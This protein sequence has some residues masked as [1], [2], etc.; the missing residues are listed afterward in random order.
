MGTLWP[1]SQESLVNSLS[2]LSESLG[3]LKA[4]QPIDIWEVTEHLQTAAESVRNLR[5]LVT[6][7]LSAASWDNR[8]EFE[9]L[10]ARIESVVE[11][12][13]RLLALATELERGSIVHR[14]ALRIGQTNQLREHAIAELRSHAE[15]RTV[16]PDL[17]GPEAGQ[18]IEWACGLKEPEDAKA[19]EALRGGFCRLDDFVTD[20]EP[21]MWVVKTKSTV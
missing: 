21:G 3:R 17:P 13:T 19:I 5:S 20:L 1:H 16:P 9:A 18:W 2:L 4:A 6:S 15:S 8:E 7:A 14:R 12:R 10:L 11:V